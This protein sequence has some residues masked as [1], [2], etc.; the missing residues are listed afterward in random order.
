MSNAHSKVRLN[1]KGSAEMPQDEYEDADV[2]ASGKLIAILKRADLVFVLAGIG[3][4]TGGRAGPA[5][6][7]ASRSRGAL[8]IGLVTGPFPYQTSRSRSAVQSLR[9]MLDACHTVIL[10]DNHSVD[11][12]SVTLP[13]RFET[14]FA[15][16]AACSIVCA[17]TGLLNNRTA[18]NGP[19]DEFRRFLMHGALA[20]AAVGEAYSNCGA[21]EAALAAL[22]KV[23]SIVDLKAAAGLLVNFTASRTTF[24]ANMTRALQLLSS[25]IGPRTNMLVG[26]CVERRLN[27]AVRVD[28]VATGMP[29]P[30]AWGGYRNIPIEVHE[31]EPESGVERP[32][33]FDLKLER[34]EPLTA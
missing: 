3:G 2:K 18:L 14:D 33:G 11:H 5:I 12:A 21:E 19:Q 25:R 34:M 24:D 22:R 4:R 8:V 30:Y 27:E 28:L 1:S 23:Q 20:K 16:A 6:A 31:L 26:R 32:L 13:F 29:F 7:E 9:R 17:I 10:L 15:G